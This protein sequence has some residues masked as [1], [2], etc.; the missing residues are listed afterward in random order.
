[1]KHFELMVH[2]VHLEK[3]IEH[4]E[5]ILEE[6]ETGH[7]HTAI[8]VLKHRVEQIENQVKVQ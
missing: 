1:M 6:H 7:F 2:K 5:S 3:E 8:S 4:L